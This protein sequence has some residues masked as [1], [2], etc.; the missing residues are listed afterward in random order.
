MTSRTP[1]S[2]IAFDDASL[3]VD[4]DAHRVTL[5]ELEREAERRGYTLGV[6]IGE[7]G[8]MTVATWL[9]LGTPGAPSVFADP[10]D[11]LLAGLTAT[12]T[13]GTKLEVRPSPRRAVGP[14]L[15]TLL[16][17]TGNRI[18]TVDRAWL[19][20]HR[21][22]ARRPNHPLPAVDLDP[23]LSKEEARLVDAIARE[24]LVDAGSSA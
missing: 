3:L 5:A 16:V 13:R 4:V 11:H 2:A 6:V 14:D 23:P 19:R 7:R 15:T 22:D 9:A 18:G 8:A 12:L 10:A 20:L 21:R 17:G 24:L 1:S